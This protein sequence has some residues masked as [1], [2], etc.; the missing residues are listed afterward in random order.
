MRKFT[1][2]NMEARVIYELIEFSRALQGMYLPQLNC[3]HGCQ[4]KRWYKDAFVNLYEEQTG[5]NT[6]NV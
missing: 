4:N 6:L 2:Q 1:K 5:D 3:S